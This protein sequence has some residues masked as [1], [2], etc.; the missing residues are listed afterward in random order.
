MEANRVKVGPK[1]TIFAGFMQ[2]PPELSSGLEALLEGVPRK[3]LAAA[4]ED[5]SAG[6]RR[7]ATSKPITTQLQAIAY[8]VARGPATFAACAAVFARL[9]EVMPEFK[10]QSLLDAGAGTGAASWATVTRW[11]EIE[12]V[13]M[14]DRNPALR[15]LA[16]RLA[17]AGPLVKAKILAGDLVAQK[18]SLKPENRA[19]LVVA[20]YVLAEL[21]QVQA[22][23]VAP[24][25]W[26]C[27][28]GALALVEPGTPEGF[29]R[30][31]MARAALI[32]AGAHVAA[33]CTHD[34][35]CP[36]QGDDWCH[37]SQ[38]LARSRDHMLL[39]DATVPFEDERYSY[40]VVT[41]RKVSSGARILAPPLE[42]KPGRT[43]KLCDE[44][45]LRAQFVAS[46]D[47]DEYARVRKRGWG[48]LF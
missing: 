28:D 29:A 40:V 48:D 9:A 37:F 44:T 36:I 33:P 27:A 42:T 19:D 12:S 35:A 13:T 25:L 30:I 11:P 17:D 6:Y 8:A 32:E 5:M 46:R 21:P 7:G 39:K 4:A 18:S 34:R 24:N 10:P 43:F 31:R 47:K 22:A 15:A 26:Q 14:L 3:E 1:C 45:G 41:R 23:S 20:S 2:F 16:R 38:R